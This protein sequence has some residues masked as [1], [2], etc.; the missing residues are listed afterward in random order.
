M[1][2]HINTFAFINISNIQLNYNL[3]QIFTLFSLHIYD[4]FICFRQEGSP[5]A[6]LI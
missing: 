6:D 2:L 5:F 3:I 4:F 1:E